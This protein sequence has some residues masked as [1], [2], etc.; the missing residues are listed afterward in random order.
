[1]GSCLSEGGQF[2]LCKINFRDIIYNT[3]AI[4]NNTLSYALDLLGGSI[5]S[6]LTTPH[7][8]S[9]LCELMDMLISL[10][11][12]IISQCIF[13]SNHQ[14]VHLKYGRERESGN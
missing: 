10:V 14:V 4:A 12:M 7:Q 3:V 5:L 9:Q 6:V 13:L 11:V 8:R 1:M 2:W